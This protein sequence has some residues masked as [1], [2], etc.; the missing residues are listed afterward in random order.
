MLKHSPP[1]LF[2][3]AACRWVHAGIFPAHRRGWTDVR[4]PEPHVHWTMALHLGCPLRSATLFPVPD[5]ASSKPAD[6][7]LNSFP[8]SVFTLGL[9]EKTGVVTVDAAADVDEH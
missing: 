5:F 3:V 4:T 2:L 6:I 8:H 9:G 1:D 7:W